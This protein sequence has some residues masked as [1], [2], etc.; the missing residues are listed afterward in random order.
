MT[1]YVMRISDWSSD[2]CSSDLARLQ[3]GDLFLDG[4]DTE[5]LVDEHRLVLADAMRTI[6]RL[7]LDRRVPPR[8]VVDDGIGRSQIEANPAGLETDQ[9][10]RHFLA[11]EAIEI[12]RAHV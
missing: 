8:V 11:L 7:I 4:A 3:L 1:A 12:G 5:Q 2:V 6:G 9:K 10:Q